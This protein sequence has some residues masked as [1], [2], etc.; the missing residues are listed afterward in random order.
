MLQSNY[1]P[2]PQGG[3]DLNTQIQFDLYIH[4]KFRFYLSFWLVYS[5]SISG[6]LVRSLKIWTVQLAAA[7]DIVILVVIKNPWKQGLHGQT[8]QQTDS[9]TFEWESGCVWKSKHEAYWWQGLL[10]QRVWAKSFISIL[11]QSNEKVTTAKGSTSRANTKRE[12][13]KRML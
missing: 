12:K 13:L 7:H 9:Q 6:E 11:S 2:H 3:F 5:F 10:W 8:E 4:L 1:V